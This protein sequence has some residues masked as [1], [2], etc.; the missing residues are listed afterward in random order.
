MGRDAFV[1]HLRP[2]L[3]DLPLDPNVLRREHDAVRPSL[4]ELFSA[5]PDKTTRDELIYRATRTYHNKLQE[6][7]N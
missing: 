2:R 3:H 5:M 7:G 1:E 4:E 6:V